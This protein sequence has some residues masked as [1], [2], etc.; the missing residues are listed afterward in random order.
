MGMTCLDPLHVRAFMEHLSANY[1]GDTYH[2]ICE[3]L[4]PFLQGCLLQADG[5]KDPQMGSLCN[6]I[7][8]KSLK[9]SAVR[10]DPSEGYDNEKK[11]LRNPFD[12]TSLKLNSS[13]LTRPKR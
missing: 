10:H 12:E 2:L 1:D 8:P 6:C 3:E 4:Q 9:S 7:L 13:I 5:E 11:R